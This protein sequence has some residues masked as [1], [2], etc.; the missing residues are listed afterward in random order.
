MGRREGY[1]FVLD[2]IFELLHLF[3]IHELFFNLDESILA[4]KT[5]RRVDDWQWGFIGQLCSL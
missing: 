1:L 2:L 4:K 3:G 5:L